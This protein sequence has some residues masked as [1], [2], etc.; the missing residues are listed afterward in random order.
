MTRTYSLRGDEMHLREL[1]ARPE[2]LLPI[3]IVPGVLKPKCSRQDAELFSRPSL[4]ITVGPR[5]L[6]A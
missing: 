5:V 3:L 1:W 6:P 4:M 2:Q